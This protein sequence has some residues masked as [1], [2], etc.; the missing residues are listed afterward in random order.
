[1][2]TTTTLSELEKQQQQLLSNREPTL[3]ERNVNT[4]LAIEPM[5]NHGE[6]A[7][8]FEAE[9]VEPEV[10]PLI[11][12]MPTMPETIDSI[13]QSLIGDETRMVRTTIRAKVNF[14]M[15]IYD[16]DVSQLL[17]ANPAIEINNTTFN[18][19]QPLGKYVE[20]SGRVGF[21]TDRLQA[22]LSELAELHGATDTY[23]MTPGLVDT[24]LSGVVNSQIAR[25]ETALFSDME[26]SD[27]GHGVEPVFP[28]QVETEEGKQE[29]L[30]PARCI[31]GHYT[32][33]FYTVNE[34]EHAS[35]TDLTVTVETN[36]HFRVP[37]FARLHNERIERT[38]RN[39]VDTLH[40]RAEQHG[41]DCKVYL[42]ARNREM[43]VPYVWSLL[44]LV[45]EV[46][47]HAKPMNINEW[48]NEVSYNADAVVSSTATEETQSL[49]NFGD[50]NPLFDIG[51]FIIPLEN[52]T[53]E[54]E[55]E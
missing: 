43:F 15:G 12:D 23:I 25:I 35:I 51:D 13:V 8:Q 7:S 18:M 54:E 41:I 9:P 19:L 45:T 33:V 5:R 21:M 29:A 36:I 10:E 39:Y 42:S 3:A 50:I 34:S 48:A 2:T 4:V 17:E 27:M 16:D 40:H 1:M 46:F 6:V 31:L 52:V 14:V 11:M 24:T 22:A 38:L 49:I 32:G 47:P 20:R 28:V 53:N 55:S 26:L 37:L 30:V 44:Q